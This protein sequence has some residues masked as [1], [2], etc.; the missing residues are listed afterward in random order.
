MKISHSESFVMDY[1]IPEKANRVL[2]IIILG[3][4]LIVIRV[5]YLA[6]IQHDDQLERARKPKRRAV[7]EKVER[8]TVRDRFN[9]PLRSIKFNITPLSAMPISVKFRL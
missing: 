6:I 4:L 2:N 8:A 1:N 7:I 5:W 3:L 9:I